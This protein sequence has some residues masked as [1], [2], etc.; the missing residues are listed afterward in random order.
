MPLILFPF[1]YLQKII[2]S[3]TIAEN[4]INVLDYFTKFTRFKYKYM[5]ICFVAMWLR[6]HF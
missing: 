6:D 2:V 1:R 5:E 3:K 4:V